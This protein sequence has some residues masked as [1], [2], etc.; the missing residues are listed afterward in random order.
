MITSAGDEF[1]NTGAN[2]AKDPSSAL[3]IQ[4]TQ[5]SQRFST[6]LHPELAITLM[7]IEIQ[8]YNFHAHA[9][10]F[11]MVNTLQRY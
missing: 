2:R 1:F 5:I 11:S 10:T 3:L 4:L 8:N 9:V 6:V 7:N